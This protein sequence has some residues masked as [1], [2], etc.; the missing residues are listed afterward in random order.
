MH[1]KTD[2]IGRIQD[3]SWENRVEN[4]YSVISIPSLC[5]VGHKVSIMLSKY[6]DHHLI[7]THVFKQNLNIWFSCLKILKMLQFK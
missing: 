7:M 4:K 1:A 5:N 6:E 2:K 3:A